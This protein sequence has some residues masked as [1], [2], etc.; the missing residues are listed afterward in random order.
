[1]FCYVLPRYA[2]TYIIIK[3]YTV[4]ALPKFLYSILHKLIAV[5]LLALFAGCASEPADPA[6]K[7]PPSANVAK[8]Q[9]W[10]DAEMLAQRAEGRSAAAGAGNSMLPIYGDHTMLV[11]NAVPY[12]TL[13]PGMTVAYRNSRGVEVVHKLIGKESGGWRVA[14]LNNEEADEE[15]VTPFNL[16]GVIYATLN[17]DEDEESEPSK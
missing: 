8:L 7:A 5:F 14:G 13:R 3:F 11:I 6:A 2:L 10:N 15:L 12:D 16:I 1:M 17:Y 9:A 4:Q